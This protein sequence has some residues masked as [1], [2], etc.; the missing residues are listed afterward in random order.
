MIR[1]RSKSSRNIRRPSSKS[2]WKNR[3]VSGP[4][5]NR[6]KSLNFHVCASGSNRQQRKRLPRL[7]PKRPRRKSSL[8]PT[9]SERRRPMWDEASVQL[10]HS[11]FQLLPPLVNRNLLSRP[12]PAPSRQRQKNRQNRIFRF[13]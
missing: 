2:P 5:W 12:N 6:S 10:H 9:L 8:P 13:L 11:S 1:L 7:N 4:R 3:N